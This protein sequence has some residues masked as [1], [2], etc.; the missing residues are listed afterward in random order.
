METDMG[1]YDE[2]VLCGPRARE[3]FCRNCHQ[4][5]LDLTSHLWRCGNCLAPLERLIVGA[6]GTLDKEALIAAEQE[7][8]K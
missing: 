4:L 5:R 1:G 2:F 8:S 3:Y 7:D 6:P